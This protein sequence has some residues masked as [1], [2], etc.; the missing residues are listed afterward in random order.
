MVPVVRAAFPNI[1]GHVE[2]PEGIRQLRA[3]SRSAHEVIIGAL[4][5]LTRFIIVV[6]DMFCETPEK[7]GETITFVSQSVGGSD[8]PCVSGHLASTTP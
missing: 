8:L 7:V 3:D 5:D 4:S 1:S 2:K 6:S